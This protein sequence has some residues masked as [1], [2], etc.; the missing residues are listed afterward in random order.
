[1]VSDENIGC[2]FFV[3]VYFQSWR[4]FTIYVIYW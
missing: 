1:M 4:N 3:I 2:I